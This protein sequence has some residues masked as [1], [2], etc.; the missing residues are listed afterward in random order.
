MNQN[1][2]KH[3]NSL[4]LEE[5]FRNM[6]KKLSWIDQQLK[7]HLIRQ[8]N[9]NIKYIFVFLNDSFQNLAHK[10]HCDSTRLK[11]GA[12]VAIIFVIFLSYTIQQ[13]HNLSKIWFVLLF[14]L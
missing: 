4:M 8:S 11:K 7:L 5:T 13:T 14:A 6:L 12:F 10:T 3:L 2:S 9:S 1:T